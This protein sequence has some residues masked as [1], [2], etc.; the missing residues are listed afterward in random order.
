MIRCQPALGT[1]VEIGAYA[2]AP[3]IEPK[4]EAQLHQTIDAA[5]MAIH[6]VQH[7][8]SVFDRQS[9]L[10]RIN[11]G[12]F[13]N[14]KG[15]VHPW[16]WEVLSLSKKIHSISSDFDPCVC[17]KLVDFGVRPRLET[18]NSAIAGSIDHVLLL[19]DYCIQTTA[20]VYIDLGGIA[21]GAA[22]DRAIEVL[23]THGVHSGCVNAGGDLRVFGPNPNNIYVRNPSAPQQTRLIGTLQDGA[24][25]SSG[26]YFVAQRN[27]SAVQTGHLIDPKIG[28]PIST[29]QSFS[30]LAST[31]AVAD[32]LTKVYAITGDAHHPAMDYFDA[33][34]LE[35]PEWLS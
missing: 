2:S 10:S 16:L 7:C 8:M 9:D 6:T 19:E 17:Q 30:V 35:V 29:Q 27:T 13:L 5:F 14:K 3:E 24:M 1:Y 4:I 33:H 18:T 12:D 20:A 11:R 25:A 28:L 31:C 26:D 23:Q 34:A 22:V 32:A 15:K 21:K